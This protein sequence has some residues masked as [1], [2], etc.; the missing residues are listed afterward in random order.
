M[1][2]IVTTETVLKNNVVSPALPV[3]PAQYSQGEFDKFNNVLRLYFNQLDNFIS[4]FSSGTTTDGSTLTFP[5]G[6]FYQ[7]GVTALTANITNVS[8][9]PI[10]VTSTADFALTTGGLIIGTEIIGY[11]GKTATTFTGIT[12]GM[13]GSTKAAHTAGDTVTEAQTLASPTVAAAVTLL[14]TTASNQVALDATDKT[15]I[16]FSVAGYYNIQFSIQ[17]VSYDGT[18]DNVTVWWRQNGVDIPYSAGVATVPAI[19]GGVA[20]TAIISWN[21]VLP[22]NAGDNV[23]L[24]FASDTG[25]TVCATY[26]GGTSPTRPVSPSVIV[27]ATFVSALY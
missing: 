16:V 19:H 18:I 22:V 13:Y 2:Y 6:A 9:T 8:T 20:G 27:T 12:R 11:T 17:M 1:S 15:K 25:N 21:L 10:Q 7:D 5:N 26:A 4:R 23:Q 24:L 3:S 14:Q